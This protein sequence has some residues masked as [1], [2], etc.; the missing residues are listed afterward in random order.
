MRGIFHLIAFSIL[1]LGIQCKQSEFGNSCDLQSAT[2]A[3]T[4]LFKILTNLRSPHCGINVDLQLSPVQPLY[5]D[6]TQI[7]DYIKNDG[8]SAINATNTSCAGSEL[9]GYSACLHAGLM[10]SVEGSGGIFNSNN[11]DGYFAEDHLGILQFTC[12]E[13]AEGGLVFVATSIKPGKFLGDFVVLENGSYRFSPISV[14]V[15][16]TNQLVG[17]TPFASTWTNTILPYPLAGGTL[18]SPN[19]LYLLD[20]TTGSLGSSTI[21]A[22]KTGILYKSGTVL[23]LANVTPFFRFG[24]HFQF[25]EGEFNSNVTITTLVSILETNRFMWIPNIIATTSGGVLEVFGSHGLYQSIKSSAQNGGNAIRINSTGM[26]VGNLIQNNTFSNLNVGDIDGGAILLYAGG[27]SNSIWNQSILNAVIYSSTDESM[28][29]SAQNSNVGGIVIKNI[30]SANSSTYGSLIINETNPNRISGVT[31]SNL[32]SGNLNSGLGLS[33]GVG[34]DFGIVI[35]NLGIFK[36]TNFAIENSAVNNHYLT[37]NV[38]YST[39]LVNNIVSGANVGFTNSGTPAGQ[40]DFQFRANIPIETSF[41]GYSFQDDLVNPLDNSGS[42]SANINQTSY[43][44]FQNPYRSFINY[45]PVDLFTDNVKGIC[46]INCRI[47]DWSLKR[48]DVELRNTN[49]CPDL[50]RPLLHKVGGVATS[51]AEC[52]NLV[53]G[54]VYLGANAC[55]IYHLRNTIEIIGDAKGNENGLCESNEDCIFTPNL[56][57]YQGHGL[58]KKANTVGPFYCSDVPLRQDKLSRIR[59]FAY[60]ENGY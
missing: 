23:E 15:F 44:K 46:S 22:N 5:P 12:F 60:E 41:V 7:L 9:G 58:L 50:S 29:L 40:S 6:R 8:S 30:V 31:V 2:F 27:T 53:R 26:S 11:C 52:Q 47:F 42:I 51:D 33:S 35:E 59:L 4:L 19:T 21:T 34:S 56:G 25:L 57:A 18:N 10:L 48:S 24:G 38:L 55:G 1:I 3:E 14:S 17:K 49:S 37:G 20:Q 32:V 39:G 45:D 28:A 54:S 43:I 13:R 16:H 36:V